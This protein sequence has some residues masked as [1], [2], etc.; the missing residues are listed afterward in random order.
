MFIDFSKAFDTVSQYCKIYG[1]RDN[2]HNWIKS[3]L[4]NRKQHIEADPTIK[5]SLEL[6]NGVVP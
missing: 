6:V 5:D 2:N 3:Y 1:L 4:S